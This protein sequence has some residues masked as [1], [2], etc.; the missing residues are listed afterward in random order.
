MTGCNLA[1]CYVAYDIQSSKTTL[2]IPPIDPDDVIWSGLPFSIDDALAKFD[3]DEVKYTSEVNDF[4]SS[5][6]SANPDATVFAIE[7][8]VSEHVKLSSFGKQDLSHLKG[9]IEVARV[10]KDEFE[11]AMIRKANR[12]SGLGHKA[13]VKRAKTAK[14]ER[15]LYAAFLEVCVSHGGPEMAY[16]P[17]LAAGSAAATLHYV[18]NNAP[19]EGKMNLLIDAGCEWENY[20]SDIVSTS[21]VAFLI[22]LTADRL[23]AD[24]V[25]P[26]ER[27]VHARLARPV[28]RR[29]P[30]AKGDDPHDQGW[31]Q[32]ERHSP[33]CTQGRH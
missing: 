33:A 7:N 3:V 8:Q 10:V 28:R 29:A 15:E 9:S 13:V 23:C 24:Q 25:V 20:A 17:I 27:K 6:S 5:F 16:H 22:R 31:R 2:F 11:V 18:D 21:R 30:D 14:N 26:L 32:L 1:D 4:L 12:I 19:L